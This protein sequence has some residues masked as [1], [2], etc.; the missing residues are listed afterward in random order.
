[1]LILEETESDKLALLKSAIENKVEISFW[2]KGIDY[3][4][5]KKGVPQMLNKT[6]DLHNLQI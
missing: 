2:Y 1:M 4:A 3:V 6:G 5:R